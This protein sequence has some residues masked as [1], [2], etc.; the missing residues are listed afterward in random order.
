MKSKSVQDV[1]EQPKRVA[2]GSL[3]RMVS[4]FPR[5]PGKGWKAYELVPVWEHE[6]GIRVHAGGLC[7]LKDGTIIYGCHWP[8]SQN[9]Q[10]AIREQGGTTRRGL[11]VWGL[12]IAANTKL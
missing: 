4:R 8:E 3:R 6:S 11:M 12:E 7:R 10:Q 5:R 9:L 2:R 1:T